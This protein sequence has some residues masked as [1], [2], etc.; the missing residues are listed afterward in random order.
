[1]QPCFFHI[2]VARLDLGSVSMFPPADYSCFSRSKPHSSLK[3]ISIRRRTPFSQEDNQYLIESAGRNNI[4]IH[5]KQQTERM[6]GRP[7]PQKPQV[8][9]KGNSGGDGQRQKPQQ[10]AGG[11]EAVNPDGGRRG[12]KEAPGTLDGLKSGVDRRTNLLFASAK[13]PKNILSAVKE[14]RSDVTK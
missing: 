1:M 9:G 7:G 5:Q 3:F 2:V 8:G 4:N 6:K 12:D 14:V 11:A 10:P 13:L